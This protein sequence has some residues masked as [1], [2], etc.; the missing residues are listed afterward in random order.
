MA[1]PGGRLFTSAF[2]ALAAADLVYFT[3]SGLL[4]A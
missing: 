2:I 3:A 4:L 1:D